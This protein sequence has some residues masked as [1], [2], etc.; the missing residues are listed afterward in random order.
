[1]SDLDK[2]QALMSEYLRNGVDAQQLYQYYSQ[3][4]MYHHLQQAREKGELKEEVPF[5]PPITELMLPKVP[6]EAKEFESV[7]ADFDNKSSVD[8]AE[9]I[10]VLD[11]VVFWLNALVCFGLEAKR[12]PVVSLDRVR[13]K[14]QTLQDMA[15]PLKHWLY[16]HRDNPY[17][18]KSEKM[19][20][21]NVSHMTLTQV[22]NWF[23]NAR[24]RLKNT[25]R[26]PELN[27]ESR[28]KMYN[29]CV[30]GNQELL[31]IDSDDDEEEMKA[32]PQ[33]TEAEAVASEEEAATPLDLSDH[34]VPGEAIPSP[35]P[36]PPMHT[37]EAPHPP[38][39]KQCILQRYLTDSYQHA[40]QMQNEFPRQRNASGSLS[41]HDYEEISTSFA[42]SPLREHQFD[43]Q[44]EMAE[45]LPAK[46]ENA[47]VKDD[48]YWK[49][50]SAALALTTLAR[51]KVKGN[52][53]DT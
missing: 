8:R 35:A 44:Q 15:R 1:M 30:E 29:S 4:V 26:D 14:R 18:T 36:S 40:A 11:S 19:T 23:A 41:S 33:P 13:H 52:S 42:G 28:I 7:G 31:S 17:P 24:R 12:R 46:V 20:L 9:D 22:S 45:E 37:D 10:E 25:V 47:R 32:P 5:Q 49:E 51:S 21:A 48:L 53:F 3:H 50:I 2:L 39:Y 34:T 6:S 43:E 38:K 16:K 27:W